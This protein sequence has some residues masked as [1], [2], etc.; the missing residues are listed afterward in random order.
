MYEYESD[1]H[2]EV[3]DEGTTNEVMASQKSI[4]SKEKQLCKY[5]FRFD[6]F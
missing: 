1:D 3:D 2:E 5:L 6:K 4:D